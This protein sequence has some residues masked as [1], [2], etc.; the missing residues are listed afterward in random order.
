MQVRT[1]SY[2]DAGLFDIP[3]VIICEDYGA[4]ESRSRTRLATTFRGNGLG[5]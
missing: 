3:S 5:V 4:V 1:E 2:K